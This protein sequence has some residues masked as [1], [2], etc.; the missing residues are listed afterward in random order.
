[1]QCSF[2]TVGVKLQ[3]FDVLMP[4]TPTAHAMTPAEIGPLV[5]AD[6]GGTNARFGWVERAGQVP[7]EVQ[8]LPAAAFEGPGEAMRH[9][10]AALPP[11]LR[12]QAQGRGLHAGWALATAVSGDE[13][14]MTNNHW[15][16]SRREEAQR[17]ALE[18]LRV[19]NDFEALA[20]SL[21]HLTPHQLRSWDGRMPSLQGPLAV[22]G[23]GTGLGVAG[24]VPTRAGWQPLAG[25]GGHM[26]LTAHDAFED[27]VLR[28]ARTVWP[29]VSAERLL[30]GIGLP[31]LHEAV[32]RVHG[33]PVQPT[34]TEEVVAQG[35]AGHVAARRTLE[36]FCAMLGGFVG[37]VALA[38]GARGGV[39]IGGGLV[40]RL[41]ELFFESEFRQRFE[42]KGRL[43][44]YVA[45]MP[46]VLITDTLAALQGVSSAMAQG[47]D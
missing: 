24:M 1:M 35:L 8:T 27:E 22:I 46:T 25:E 11:G 5:V 39:F 36:V 37:N 9:Y 33:E 6:I 30:S 12:A 19:F 28:H 26:T 29:H 20:S 13:V 7:V 43:S 41:G 15:R 21:P 16:F 10:L 14:V 38:L 47:L 31:L 18:N 4:A 2:A 40:P 34:K 44:S 42:S 17:L 3:I 23:P 32:C 45:E